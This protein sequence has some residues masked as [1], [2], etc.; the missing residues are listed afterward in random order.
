VVS[1]QQRAEANFAFFLTKKCHFSPPYVA[2]GALFES[3]IAPL[4]RIKGVNKNSAVAEPRI[5][6]KAQNEISW[7]SARN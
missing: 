3:N 7:T 4:N 6:L 2:F 1:D 5:A